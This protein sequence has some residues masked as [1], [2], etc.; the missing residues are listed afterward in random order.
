[1]PKPA[2]LPAPTGRLLAHYDIGEVGIQEHKAFVI[3]RLFEEGDSRDLRWL[4]ETFSET[5]LSDWLQEYGS[6]R[7]SKRSL[8]FWATV[9]GSTG[10]PTARPV[11][12]EDLWLL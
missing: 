7:L 11:E 6:R 9:L 3:G 5:E 10:A 12:I 4:T 8:A 2:P 1:M